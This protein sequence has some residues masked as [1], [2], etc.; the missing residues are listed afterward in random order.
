M[1]CSSEV[2]CQSLMVSTG[3]NT[4]ITFF[5]IASSHCASEVSYWRPQFGSS[6]LFYRG[7]PQDL[8][9][10]IRKTPRCLRNSYF[11]YRPETRRTLLPPCLLTHPT[12]AICF[13]MAKIVAV[14]MSGVV[15]L[16]SARGPLCIIDLPRAALAQ[17]PRTV[18]SG[19]QGT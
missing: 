11:S 2:S 1:R 5:L 4:W 17:E 3:C 9:G 18:H 16:F 19:P 13:H 15:T 8:G 7:K 10:A 12:V 14:T 6:A